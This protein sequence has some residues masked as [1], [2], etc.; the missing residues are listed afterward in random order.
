M[1][2]LPEHITEDTLAKYFAGEADASVKNLVEQWVDENPEDFLKYKMLWEDLGIIGQN[3]QG[4]EEVNVDAAWKKFKARKEKQKSFSI[5]S[6]WKF[7]ASLLL[8]GSLAW[9]VSTQYFSEKEL[10]AETNFETLQVALSDHSVVTLNQKSQLTY[11]EEFS[12]D[13]RKVYLRGEAFFEISEN[14]DKPFVINIGD[15]T[16][17]VLGTSFNI[18]ATANFDTVSV[19]VETGKVRFAYGDKELILVAGEK[20]MLYA[21]NNEM[22]RT[23]RE[24]IGVDQFWRTQKLT[25]SGQT[26][27]EITSI[28]ETVFGRKFQL[29]NLAL[30]QCR[31]NVSFEKQSLDEILAIMA[32]TLDLQIEQTPSTIYIDG[33]GCDAQ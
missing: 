20:G 7:A 12:S 13:T 17:T 5:T 30:D 24:T 14:K 3:A 33:K 32:L 11:P 18:R 19:N 10:Y 15:A 22:I 26:L 4:E 16:V 1:E 28:L 23:P 25:F 8:L 21:A 9:Y 29:Q 27:T 2:N 31:L 6:V